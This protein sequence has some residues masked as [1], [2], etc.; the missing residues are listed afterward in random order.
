MFVALS[1]GQIAGFHSA[2]LPLDGWPVDATTT[3]GEFETMPALVRHPYRSDTGAPGVE[4]VVDPAK[5]H[6]AFAADLPAER[7]AVMAATQRPVADAAFS[8]RATAPAWKDRSYS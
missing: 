7:A 5:F 2:G 4:F 6:E 3:R 1:N 8:D